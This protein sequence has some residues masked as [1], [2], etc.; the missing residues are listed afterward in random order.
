MLI[1]SCSGCATHGAQVGTWIFPLLVKRAW[2]FPG[3][4]VVKNHLLIQEMWVRPLIREDPLEK[5]RA[6][7]SSIF[8]WRMPWMEEPGGLQPMGSQRVR[9]DLATERQQR[10]CRNETSFFW[11]CDCSSTRRVSLEAGL[12]LMELSLPGTHL[13]PHPLPAL[14]WACVGRGVS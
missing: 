10:G 9:H 12:Q 1:P 13:S 7:H 14:R 11:S 4:S 2:G 6:T 5:E 8:A 3:G